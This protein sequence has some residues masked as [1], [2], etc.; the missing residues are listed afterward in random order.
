[1]G[2]TTFQKIAYF[3]TEAGLPTGLR[4]AKG[5]YG[6]FSPE[7]KGVVTRLVNNGLLREERA[8]ADGRGTSL[9]A[10]LGTAAADGI[11]RFEAALR[12]FEAARFEVWRVPPGG[13]A[14]PGPPAALLGSAGAVDRPTVPSLP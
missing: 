14:L 10:R 8:L 7:V 6:P 12:G 3:A 4:Y 11:E 13:G 2:R 5:S 9:A 1:V